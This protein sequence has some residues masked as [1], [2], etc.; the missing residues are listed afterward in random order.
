[1]LASVVQ[2]VADQ[3]TTDG[4]AATV[5]YGRVHLAQ[6][7]PANRVVFCSASGSHQAPRF[8]GG[9][10]R[11]VADRHVGCEVHVW[12]AAPKQIDANDQPAADLLAAET[13][14]H[15]T[16]R[17]LHLGCGGSLAWGAEEWPEPTLDVR[18]G[19]E[20]V[21]HFTVEVPVKDTTYAVVAPDASI[22]IAPELVPPP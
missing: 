2:F 6:N 19:R 10:P 13:L 12:G 22:A 20:C 16:M 15:A 9:N 14:L 3:F 17:A 4:T 8:P 21:F 18:F 5:L 7:T 1:M 11:S